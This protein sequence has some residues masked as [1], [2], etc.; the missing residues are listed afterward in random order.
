MHIIYRIKSKSTGF[1]YIGRTSRKLE[2]RVGQHMQ[3]AFTNKKKS[4][5]QK[6]IIAF[7]IKDFDW[8]IIRSCECYNYAVYL[9]REEIKRVKPDYNRAPSHKGVL[10]IEARR[11]MGAASKGRKPWNWARKGV[12]TSEQIER[13][14]LAKKGKPGNK[15]SD[16]QRENQLKA[17]K[18]CRKVIDL[19]TG[20]IYHSVSE[21]S[22][23]L[24][25]SRSAVKMMLNGTIKN[26]RNYLLR[27]HTDPTV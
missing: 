27:Y 22:R 24:D 8:E 4:L 10:S 1:V 17:N 26:P 25:I 11:K 21:V 18:Q 19:K 13:F 12:Y 20:A 23:A 2:A 16:K 9:E 7:G 14:S 6:H 3:T 15:W 5:F